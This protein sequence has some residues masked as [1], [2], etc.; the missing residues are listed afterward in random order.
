MTSWLPSLTGLMRRS[1]SDGEVIS[2]QTKPPLTQ[3]TLSLD[4]DTIPELEG[5]SE[6]FSEDLVSRL[7]DHLPARII[8][9]PWR[10]LFTTSR[11]GFSLSSLYRSASTT[12]RGDRLMN[13]FQEVPVRHQ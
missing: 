3:Q 2:L 6:I 5:D 8:G 7:A 12:F 1:R 9:T 11:D 13:H 10:L 4:L